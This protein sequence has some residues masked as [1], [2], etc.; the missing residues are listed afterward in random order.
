MKLPTFAFKRPSGPALC[1]AAAALLGLAVVPRATY[2]KTFHVAQAVGITL[3]QSTE[4]ACHAIARNY[5]QLEDPLGYME[6][7]PPSYQEAVRKDDAADRDLQEKLLKLCR[8]YAVQRKELLQHAQM[9]QERFPPE[10]EPAVRLLLQIA[11]LSRHIDDLLKEYDARL[12]A[13]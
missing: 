5:Q 2:R 9:L 8:A 13:R 6:D 3:K 1:I 7:S 4:R 11:D 10:F 12:A